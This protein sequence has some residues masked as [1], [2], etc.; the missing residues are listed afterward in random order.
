MLAL[1]VLIGTA[2]CE[3]RAV[4]HVMRLFDI[5]ECERISLAFCQDQWIPASIRNTLNEMIDVDLLK[6]PVMLLLC[7][8]NLLGM[9][10]FYVPFMFLINMAVR[11][12]M[13]TE[14]ASLLLSLIG[15]TNTLGRIVIGWLAD[16]RWVSALSTS[17]MSLILCGLLTC[18]CPL[19]SNRAF[20]IVYATLFGFIISAYI[21]LTSI[22]LT[23]LLGLDRLTNSFG[24]VVVSRGIASLLG[25]P[26]AGMVYD[27]TS[28]YSAPFYFA[29]SLMALA[30]IVS[31]AIS[32]LRREQNRKIDVRNKPR[33]LVVP[34]TSEFRPNVICDARESPEIIKDSQQCGNIRMT[35]GK[36]R[37]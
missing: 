30:G 34:K 23:D 22:V 21:C 31:C 26:I 24:L 16:R 33:E 10:G 3:R 37:T 6:E 18:L 9:L 8:S 4:V 19:P 27:A 1:S 5:E 28:T 36:V 13:P 12:G 25:P 29:G 11:K 20:L 15:I 35:D 7:I 17:N 32:H 2:Y 14:D